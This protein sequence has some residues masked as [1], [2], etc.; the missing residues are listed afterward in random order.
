MR[1][2]LLLPLPLLRLASAIMFTAGVLVSQAMAQGSP[3]APAP[4]DDVAGQRFEINDNVG[5]LRHPG[6]A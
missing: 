4:P 5:E 1:T 3:P 6:Q 2:T